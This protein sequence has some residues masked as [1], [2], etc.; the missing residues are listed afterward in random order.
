[1]RYTLKDYQA[2][3]TA[4]LI[5]SLRRA[6][7]DLEGD[8]SDYWSVALS[9]P[10]GAG[11]TV[12]AS[13]VIETL[14]DGGGEFAE[15]PLATVLWVTDD[16]A[17]NEQTKR[18]MNQAS[19]TLG[20]SRLKTID[21]S[22]DQEIFEPRRVYFLNIQK[23]ARSNPLSR[24]NTNAREYSLWQTIANT[25]KANGAHFYVVIDEA[26]RGMKSESDRATI[27]SRIINGQDGL[28]P[29][30]PIVW[31][32][33][34]TPERFNQAIARWTVQ[35]TNKMITVPLEAV[36]GSGLLKDKIVL[37]NP[38]AGQVE[39]DTSF[40]RAGV[41][42]T[43][44]F[45]DDW[46]TYAGEQNEPPVVPAMVVQVP[47]KP[48]EAEMSE[49][50]GTIF[51]AWDDLHDYNVVNTFGEH[52]AISVNGWTIA[53]MAPQDIQDDPQ[54]RVVLCKDA[55]STGWDCP[56]A[57][58]LVSLRPAVE[59]TYIAQMIGRMVRTPLAR[60]I[61]TNQTLNDVHCYLPRFNKSQVQGIV[62]RFSEG[63][64]DEPPVEIVV[65]PVTI[66]RNTDVD[67]A[68]FDL[69]EAL[70][71]YVVPG[72]LYRTQVS[73]LHSLA[74]LLTGDNI[75]EGAIAQ[76]KAQL[77]AVLQAQ[78]ERLESDGTFQRDLERVRHL[79]IERSYA[80]LAAETLED[81]PGEASYEVDRDD[82]NIE[83]LYRVAKRKLPEGVATNYWDSVIS[84]Q[85]EDDYD[86]IEAKAI[87]AVL[88]LHSEVVEA[89]E[90]A[91]EQ[92]VR[93][94][95]REHQR[96][97]SKL[98]DA[99]KALY[100][101]IKRETRSA[102][103]TELILP[104]SR[105]VSDSPQKWGKHV[106]ATEDGQYPLPIKG[107]EL[108]VLECEL[109]DTDLVAWYR[110]P[111]GGTSA[112]RIAYRGSQ[113]DKSMYPDFVMF[114]NTDAGIRPSIIDP[115]GFFLADATVK[116]KG[117]AQYAEKHGD[118]YARIDA[119]A[120]VKGKLLALDLKSEAVRAELADVDDN[121]VEAFFQKHAGD[122]A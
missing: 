21:A 49:I 115:H 68:V 95:L 100:E 45:E 44:Q 7:R 16:P 34:A 29:P 20:P 89:V 1:M 87:T 76:V 73:R 111:V 91:A 108:Q 62:D 119:V 82:N 53:Y 114:H 81:L 92:A 83:D 110:N 51:G 2:S 38:A 67:P 12:I 109:K 99:K 121:E 22:F 104:T 42:Q 37:D 35:R 14:F 113:F 8:A 40:I 60:K 77:T 102:E 25:I 96:S 69:L 65:D 26:H 28:N 112:L 50:L 86:P 75:V 79:R 105:T 52:T 80:L 46:R 19:S 88:A 57:E 98:S 71:T 78:R 63:R 58:V 17:L 59:Y 66:E 90:S 30:A 120:E 48:S 56:R 11:K 107:W 93:S 4:E 41:E 18:N 117:L 116:L 64:S 118:A 13:A 47:N 103:Q 54:V 97:I 5:R 70:P 85:G 94:W 106:L 61:A 10:T 9:A 36:R 74:T 31:G 6:T 32:I 15:D 55:I 3:K 23:L 122:Y 72:K 43:L 33:S 27:V 39:G 24:S 101:P 84:A